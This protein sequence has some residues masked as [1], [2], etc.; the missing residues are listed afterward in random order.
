MMTMMTLSDDAIV[1]RAVEP[2]DLEVMSLLENDMSLWECGNT[3]V[4]YSMHVLREYIK[5]CSYNF[6]ED[7]VVRLAIA[8]PEGIAV[9][10]IDL[11]NYDPRHQR[12]EVGIVLM[13]ECQH[14]GLARRALSLLAGYARS[15]LYLHQIYAQVQS[16]NH[17]ALRLFRAAGFT[18][19]ATLSQWTRCAD[20]WCDVEVFQLVL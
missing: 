14:H 13:P 20:G 5:Q 12:A 3:T 7:H 6:H 19:T 1:L 15:V 8:L 2:E 18:H 4:P 17:P 10:F 16:T 11:Q 9:G